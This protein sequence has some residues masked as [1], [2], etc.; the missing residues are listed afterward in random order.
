MDNSPQN[1]VTQAF[2]NIHGQSGLPVKKQK[3]IEDFIC[4]NRIYN[5]H[6]HGLGSELV[7]LNKDK[8]CS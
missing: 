6:C 7:M 5:L 2:L 1:T 3:Q 4:R 8:G